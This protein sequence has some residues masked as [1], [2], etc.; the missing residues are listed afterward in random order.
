[1]A[2][3]AAAAAQKFKAGRDKFL[4]RKRLRLLRPQNQKWGILSTAVRLNHLN[5]QKVDAKRILQAGSDQGVHLK[6]GVIGQPCKPSVREDDG[7]GCQH[8]KTIGTMRTSRPDSDSILLDDELDDII[9]RESLWTREADASEERTWRSH[10]SWICFRI[11]K[12]WRF[13]AVSLCVVI[14]NA[15]QVGAE[16]QFSL[17]DETLTVLIVFEHLFLVWYITEFGIWVGAIG[18]AWMKS[19]WLKVDFVFCVLGVFFGWIVPPILEGLQSNLM[20]PGVLVLL[21]RMMR[22][23]RLGRTLRLLWKFKGLLRLVSGMSSSLSTMLTTVLML[24]LMLYFFSCFS[25]EFIT[26]NSE[27]EKDAAFKARVDEYYPDLWIS[28]MSLF[29]YMGMDSTSSQY[30]YLVKRAWYLMAMYTLLIILVHVILM[31]LVSA[32]M[33]E[34]TLDQKSDREETQAEKEQQTRNKIVCK[35]EELCQRLDADQSGFLSFEELHGA[36]GSEAF[37]EMCDR[38]DIVEPTDVLK[39]LDVTEGD[40]IKIKDFIDDLMV[41]SDLKCPGVYFEIDK[42]FS[43]MHL[44][45]NRLEDELG[46]MHNQLSEVLVRREERLRQSQNEKSRDANMT[47]HSDEPSPAKKLKKKVRLSSEKNTLAPGVDPG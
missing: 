4:E 40:D 22:L 2:F 46:S 16:I 14:A 17:Q 9:L 8:S 43:K 6:P 19:M 21:T 18:S 15:V 1:M 10:I 3:K 20:D 45:L 31:D 7:P 27:V 32:I 38:V 24:F 33:I 11:I 34:A 28:M 35:L 39:I 13:D 44:R 30:F 47:S 26:N 12:N 37:L 29:Q 25:V 5:P 23:L 42:R 41:L 36:V